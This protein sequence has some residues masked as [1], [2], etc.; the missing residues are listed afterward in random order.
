MD[1]PVWYCTKLTLSDI[2]DMTA[3]SASLVHPVMDQPKHLFYGSKILFKNFV[4]IKIDVNGS[5]NEKEI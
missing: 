5:R 1:L 2:S 3:D 4:S